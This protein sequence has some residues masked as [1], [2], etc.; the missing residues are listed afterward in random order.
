MLNRQQARCCCTAV[1][2]GTESSHRGAGIAAG[3]GRRLLKVEHQR[4]G[5]GGSGGWGGE[6]SKKTRGALPQ[7]RI[8]LSGWRP[9]LRRGAGARLSVV[10]K[11]AMLGARGRLAGADRAAQRMWIRVARGFERGLAAGAALRGGVGGHER[12]RLGR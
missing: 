4:R 6:G 3:A 2:A 11:T 5:G 12:L 10:R 8:W 7:M 1:E 9:C